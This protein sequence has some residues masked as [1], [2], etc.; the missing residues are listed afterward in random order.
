MIFYNV[1]RSFAHSGDVEIRPLKATLHRRFM[2]IECFLR[3]IIRI[4]FFCL[5]FVQ[6]RVQID[7]INLFYRLIG[8]FNNSNMAIFVHK[9]V[10]A[11]EPVFEIRFNATI[12]SWLRDIGNIRHDPIVILHATWVQSKNARIH[13]PWV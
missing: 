13:Q 8:I 12:S 1:V 7:F 5:R 2:W 4:L 6:Q 9:R 3:M 11:L 10:S